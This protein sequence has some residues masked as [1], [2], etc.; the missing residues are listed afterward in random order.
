MERAYFLGLRLRN[1]YDLLIRDVKQYYKLQES[2]FEPR[3][4]P[5]IVLLDGRGAMSVT[6]IARELGQSHVAIVQLSAILEKKGLICTKRDRNDIR[7]R[8]LRLSPQ[9]IETIA[10]LTPVWGHILDATRVLLEENAPEFLNQLLKLEQALN[11]ES[12]LERIQKI[13]GNSHFSIVPFQD[14]YQEDFFRLNE[15]WLIKYFG[16]A[17]KYDLEM[18]A[19]PGII[20]DQEGEIY[21]SRSR[22]I[23]TG[24]FSLIKRSNKVL[25]L[26]KL[27]VHEDYRR[28]GIGSALVEKAIS[29][30]KE[31][32]AER[33]IL[34]TSPL[35]VAANNLYHRKGFIQVEND[36]PDLYR[37]ETIKMQ[38]NL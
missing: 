2:D 9:G 12:L 24:T 4:F 5:L 16:K 18:L 32:R 1:V 11:D 10:K 35:L 6:E 28:Q 3:W 33:L 20:L 22:D 31:C 23:I 36:H 37:R 7:R 25:E 15:Q 8:L 19:N 21:F 17:E 38:I 26:A 14:K 34:F 30:A 29:R 27:A 13:A